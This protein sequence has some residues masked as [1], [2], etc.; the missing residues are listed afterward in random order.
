MKIYKDIINFLKYKKK[1]IYKLIFLL[2][3]KYKKFKN[4][5]LNF[6]ICFILIYLLLNLTFYLKFSFIFLFILYL[7]IIFLSINKF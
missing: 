1:F 7:F 2:D 6:K 3:I 5:V 4:I